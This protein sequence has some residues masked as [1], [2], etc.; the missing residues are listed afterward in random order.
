MKVSSDILV[1]SALCEVKEFILS[2]D[3]TV[4]K[5]TSISKSSLSLPLSY[6]TIE[7]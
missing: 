6:V 1:S 2:L 5:Y 7:P 4:M 3:T